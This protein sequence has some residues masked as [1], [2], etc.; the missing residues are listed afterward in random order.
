MAVMM[1]SVL[2]FIALLVGT[3]PASAERGQMNERSLH[4]STGKEQK[5]P[6]KRRPGPLTEAWWKTVGDPAIYAFRDCAIVGI[7]IDP[8]A[9]SPGYLAGT[10][11]FRTCAKE[12]DTLHGV[13]LKGYG[14]D[15]KAKAA[16][17][18]IS[19]ST[20]LPAL[21]DAIKRKLTAEAGQGAPQDERSW[22][23]LNELFNCGADSSRGQATATADSAAAIVKT[24]LS[25]CSP[26]L[27]DYV[28]VGAA[29]AAQKREL[30]RKTIAKFKPFVIRQITDVRAG[31]QPPE[32][33]AKPDSG[34]LATGQ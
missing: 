15:D 20:I 6:Q 9:T 34:T 26:L 8:D 3:I 21:N 22:T 19:Q 29:T 24:V 18:E 33:A 32:T 10:T 13:L 23:A 11:V 14:D 27:T 16:F 4:W 2:V 5:P 31:A 17:D 30:E 7:T 1:R 25:Q 12:F 28:E